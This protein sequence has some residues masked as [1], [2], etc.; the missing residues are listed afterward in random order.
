MI[1][2]TDAKDKT[3]VKIK[4][5]IKRKYRSRREVTGKLLGLLLP[6]DALKPANIHLW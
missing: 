6:G 4:I 5:K 2:V 1:Q 3:K